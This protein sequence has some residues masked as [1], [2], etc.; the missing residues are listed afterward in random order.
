MGGEGHIIDMNKRLEQNRALRVSNRKKEAKQNHHPPKK[1][2]LRVKKI[3]NEKLVLIISEIKQRQKK[4]VQK[5][6]FYPLGLSFF[7]C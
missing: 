6:Y 4:I 7:S 5:L 1:A 2:K 3:S